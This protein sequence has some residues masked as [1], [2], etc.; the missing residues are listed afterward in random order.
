MWKCR[1]RANEGRD[2]VRERIRA[3]VMDFVALPTTV[4][5]VRY[6]GHREPESTGLHNDNYRPVSNAVVPKCPLRNFATGTISPAG[7]EASLSC[8]RSEYAR[9]AMPLSIH[10]PSTRCTVY[11]DI[12][13]EADEIA[14]KLKEMQLKKVYTAVLDDE[15]DV[16][17][18]QDKVSPFSK[19]HYSN[20]PSLVLRHSQMRSVPSADEY[21]KMLEKYGNIVGKSSLL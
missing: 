11:D 17:D 6:D 1:F 12:D 21:A 10:A 19:M 13:L 4:T 2:L 18:S 3:D 5:G 9:S 20:V 15:T 14:Q 7:S 8:P 16:D